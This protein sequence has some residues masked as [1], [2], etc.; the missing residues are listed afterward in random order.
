MAGERVVRTR[1]PAER[2]EMWWIM[3][4]IG[5]RFPRL[6]NLAVA[7]GLLLPPASRLRRFGVRRIVLFAFAALNRRDFRLLQQA[8][9]AP[10]VELVFHREV[11]PE[12]APSYRGR[13]AAYDA[14]RQW[15]E[16]W[17]DLQREP[18]EVI[19]AGN[20]LLILQR[21]VGRTSGIQLEERVATLF[22]LRGRRIVRQDEYG[23]WD[24]ALEAIGF[25]D[26]RPHA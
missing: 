3:R 9:Y 1:V 25:R 5:E 17:E 23:D 19:D 18:V 13:E 8:A 15:I 24:Q 14:Y 4:V 10:E 20:R 11:P 7:P 22:T 2:P 26:Q 16:P 12:L 6:L 21:E